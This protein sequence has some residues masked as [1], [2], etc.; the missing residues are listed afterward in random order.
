LKFD[1]QD[2]A[3][4]YDRLAELI[5]P[6]DG[7]TQEGGLQLNQSML[8]AWKEK[9]D[10]V[11][12]DVDPKHIPANTGSFTPTGTMNDAR[13]GHTA[14][15]LHEGRVLV[16]GGRE[17]E[18][19]VLNTA[20]IYDPH[21]GVFTRT[22][23][24]TE[25]RVGHTA[26]LLPDGKVLITGGSG[27]DH[28]YGAL[29]TAELYDP[30]NGTFHATGRMHDARLEHQATLLAN[31]K[32]LITGGQG[33]K[34]TKHNSAELYDPATGAFTLVGRMTTPRS[35]HCATLL[36]DGRVLMTGGATTG[37][38]S[39]NVV[40]SAEMYDPIKQIFTLTG[41]MSVARHKHSAIRLPD[42]NVLIIGGSNQYLWGGKHA[43][44]DLYNP[45][46]GTFTPTGQMKSARYKMRD[47]C[48]LLRNGK[49][50][51]T[52]GGIRAEIYD[53]A[54]GVFA[55]VRGDMGS[56]RLYQTA[57]LLSNGDVLITGG[58]TGSVNAGLIPNTSAW[59]Y[60][61]DQ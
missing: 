41:R 24:M 16:A 56:G 7:V 9:I 52:G 36:I 50:L 17:K 26:T 12:V 45:A 19:V 28:Y 30:A 18:V 2:R 59:M 29:D 31:G 34:W 15:L 4:I 47:A 42:G 48:T 27:K 39:D 46:T 10:A 21:T 20:E 25:P 49:I 8:D 3:H 14:T 58:Y 1:N 57:T 33:Y 6:P 23:S 5:P 40:D 54:T 53:P 11:A 37:A 51:V 44:A 61:P 32:V 43:S 22:G 55:L 13:F 35:D 38:Q 60:H